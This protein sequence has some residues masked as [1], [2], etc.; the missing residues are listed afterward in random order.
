MA[1]YQRFATPRAYVCSI[2]YNLATSWNNASGATTVLGE[3]DVKD[4]GGSDVT[5]TSGSKENL[6]DMKPHNPVQI[7]DETQAFYIQYDTELGS[8]LLNTNNFIAILNHNFYSAGVVFKVEVSDEENF[9]SGVTQGIDGDGSGSGS[10]NNH[11]AV[12]N[13]A[14]YAGNDNHIDTASNGW[15]LITFPSI[16]SVNNRYIR[17]SFT[18][19]NGNTIDGNRDF[20]TDVYIG[21]LMFGKYIDWVHPMDVNLTTAYDYDGTT[22]QNSVGGSTYANST[23]FGPPAWTLTNP[24]AN[25]TT[26]NQQNYGFSR[27]YGRQKHSLNFS[28]MADTNVFNADQTADAIG[29]FTGSDLHS[30][31][32]NKIIGQHNSFMWTLDKDSTTPGD[33]GLYR[34]AD[35]AFQAKQIGSRV[36]DVKLDLIESW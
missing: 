35:S 8:N 34:L 26:S 33:Y 1:G 10:G 5:F 14:S 20:D 9:S 3:V 24:W 4:D 11:T 29:F 21:G 36:W 7:E 17:I 25:T 15:S 31:F 30:Q 12:I 28:H 32:Y 18:A 6:F 27:R 13:A 23:Y 19:H 22:L 16:T 2:N